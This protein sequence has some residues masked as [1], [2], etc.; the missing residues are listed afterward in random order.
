MPKITNPKG[1][2]MI[3]RGFI[4]SPFKALDSLWILEE[5]GESRTESTFAV[6]PEPKSSHR[7]PFG[8]AFYLLRAITAE[9]RVSMLTV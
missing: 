1:M 3:N 2:A 8:P 6:K 9:G 5:G 4:N 7:L